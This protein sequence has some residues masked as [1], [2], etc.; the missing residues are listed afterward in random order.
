MI[1]VNNSV[2]DQLGDH[3]DDQTIQGR[4]TGAWCGVVN[5]G[6]EKWSDSGEMLKVEPAGFPDGL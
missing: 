5:R 6:G 3:T 1:Y 4:H 2:G